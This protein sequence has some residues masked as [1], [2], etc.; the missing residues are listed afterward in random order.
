[1]ASLMSLMRSLPGCWLST[2]ARSAIVVR[3]LLGTNT[4]PSSVSPGPAASTGS[5]SWMGPSTRQSRCCMASLRCVIC[6]TVYASP[7]P[8]PPPTVPPP[9]LMGHRFFASRISVLPSRSAMSGWSVPSVSLS[10][11]PL[12]MPGS[13]DPVTVHSTG[14]ELNSAT[15]TSMVVSSVRKS[16]GVNVTSTSAEPCAG[17]MPDAGDTLKQGFARSSRTLNSNSIGTRQ[18]SLTRRVLASPTATLPKSMRDGNLV[19]FITGYA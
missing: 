8:A 9:L 19:V 12:W 3:L 7:P 4:P 2:Y 5:F 14:W 6:I 10:K 1:M 15:L 18:S 11:L 13:D 17:T 16:A